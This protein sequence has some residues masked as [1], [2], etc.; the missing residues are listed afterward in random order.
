ME[1][2][3]KPVRGQPSAHLGSLGAIIERTCDTRKY[4]GN[5]LSFLPPMEVTCYVPSTDRTSIDGRKPIVSAIKLRVDE[6]VTLAASRGHCTFEAQAAATGL[7]IGTIHRLRNGG[8][9]SATAVAAICS[10]YG[11]EFADVFVIGEPAES[12][13]P[14]DIGKALIA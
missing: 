14:A 7:G 8:P 12:P 5:R 10:A 13:Q 2:Q 3:R 6:F 11:V 1:V 4:L 9:A